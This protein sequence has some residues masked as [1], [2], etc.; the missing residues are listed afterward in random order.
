MSDKISMDHVDVSV[1]H[2]GCRLAADQA[3]TDKRRVEA[4]KQSGQVEFVS[5]RGTP[6]GSAAGF[7]SIPAMHMLH[8]LWSIA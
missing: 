2:W 3:E 7:T 1:C 5:G 4:R 6:P 8:L